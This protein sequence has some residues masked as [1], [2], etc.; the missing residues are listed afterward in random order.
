MAESGDERAQLVD[1][2]ESRIAE[3]EALDESS[4][5]AFNAVDWVICVL[6][7]VVIPYLALVWFSE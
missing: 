3:L 5:G 7:A 4:F 6:G 1:D 2:L